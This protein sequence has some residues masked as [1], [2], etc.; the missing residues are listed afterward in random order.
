[1][2]LTLG[3]A[4]RAALAVLAEV[5][6]RCHDEDT[7]TTAV[8]A[9]LDLLEPRATVKWPFDQFRRAL[10]WDENEIDAAAVSLL[11]PHGFLVVKVGEIRDTKT[12]LFRNFVGSNVSLFLRLGLGYF[13][14]ATLITPAG[15]LPARVGGP[16]SRYRKLGR[17]HQNILVFFKG[18]PQDMPKVLPDIHPADCSE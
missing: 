18:K 5:K 4:V 6:A 12:G 3:D 2:R 1:M 15:S 13:N 9:A 7:R 8:L 11:E 17:T 10:T 14:E 16:F